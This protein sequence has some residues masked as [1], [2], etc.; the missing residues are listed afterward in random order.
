MLIYN[1]ETLACQFWIS[2]EYTIDWKI[3]I[4]IIFNDSNF[5]VL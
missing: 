4:C 5:N 2:D 1:F 3:E